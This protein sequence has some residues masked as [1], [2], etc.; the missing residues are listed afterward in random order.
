MR[1][2]QPNLHHSPD[3]VA[4]SVHPAFAAR[5]KLQQFGKCVLRSRSWIPDRILEVVRRRIRR[6]VRWERI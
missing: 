4:V 2:N 6:G 1:L 3:I 5:T